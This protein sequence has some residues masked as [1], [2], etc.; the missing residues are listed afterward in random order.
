MTFKVIM[1]PSGHEFDAEPDESVLD[2][3]MRHGIELPYG[4]R[5]GSCGS[6]AGYLVNGEVRYA[7]EPM[8]L[9]DAMREQK[10]ALFCMAQPLTDLEIRIEEVDALKGIPVRNLRCR[11][12][13]LAHLSHDVIGMKLK[14]AGSERMQYVAGQ[15]I[16]FIL[17]DGKRRAFSIANAPHEDELIELHI[18]HVQGG[19]FTDF[20]FDHMEEKTMLRIEGPLGGFFIREESVRPIIM[21][22]GGTGFGPLKAMIEH[23]NYIGLDRSIHLFMG[24]RALRD[25]YMVDMVK[26]WQQ[27]NSKLLFTPVLS[28]PMEGDDWRGETGFVHEAVTRTYGDLSPFDI[29]MSGPPPMVNAALEAFHAK[30][31]DTGHMYSDAFEYAADTLKA[32]AD[33]RN[34]DK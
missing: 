32:I 34:N 20:L 27:A 8:G 18:R 16:E 15:Y 31:A 1:R 14:I 30:G 5:G 23:A 24:V 33:S 9:S 28:E 11:V 29:Y 2:A 13:S 10:Q 26:Q 17:E 22:G 6:C 12:E 7:E 3:A 25:L 4:C 19:K 21:M